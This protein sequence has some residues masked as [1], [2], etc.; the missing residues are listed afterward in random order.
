MK[1]A[2]LYYTAPPEKCFN[3]LKRR[4]IEI[5]TGIG[6]ESSYLE[7][8]VNSIINI[9]NVGDNFMYMVAM[10]D[11]HNQQILADKLSDATRKEV[12]IR[13][14]D[15]GDTRNIFNKGVL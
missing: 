10:F 6:D 1:E 11:C 15:G 5:W 3:E 13:M 12:H 8:K 14:V 9:K 7:E 2:K 4:A